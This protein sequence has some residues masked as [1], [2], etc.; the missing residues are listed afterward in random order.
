MLPATV[1]WLAVLPLTP[2]G[3]LDVRALPAPDLSSSTTAR[4]YLAPRNALES[5]LQAVWQHELSLATIGVRDDFFELGGNSLSAIRLHAACNAALGARLP[6]RTLLTRPTI[7]SL[8]L[9]VRES[10]EGG[11]LDG[12]PPA[13]SATPQLVTLQSEGTRAPLFCIHPQGGNVFCYVDLARRLGP[14]LPIHGLQAIG[15]EAG[16]RPLESIEAMGEAYWVQ[17]RAV[18]P[19]GPYRIA[20][21]SS[22]GLIA[23]EIAARAHDDGETVSCLILL[24]APAIAQTNSPEPSRAEVFA[25]AGQLLDADTV[26]ASTAEL[27]ALMRQRGA[28]APDF[29]LPEGE[30][31]VEVAFQTL[32]AA[33]CYRGRADALP[34]VQTTVQVRATRREGPLPDWS[35]R[36]GGAVVTHDFDC[37]HLQLMTPDLAAPVAAT[38]SPYL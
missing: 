19:V 10:A 38:L 20:G 29:G 14:D 25:D 32:R 15:L 21:Y 18:Q 12:Q 7:E 5:R 4:P 2:N 1:T 3:K 8:A 13:T 23:Y 30:R 31:L 37:T 33:R 24:D 6:L 34:D 11:L 17:I 28:V 26:P 27:V 35:P 16:E 36:C 9:A 22:G